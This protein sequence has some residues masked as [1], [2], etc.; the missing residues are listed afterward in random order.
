MEY[1]DVDYT[2]IK[3]SNVEYEV[4]NSEDVVIDTE[5][6]VLEEESEIKDE[7]MVDFQRIDWNNPVTVT[8]YGADLLKEIGKIESNKNALAADSETNR[9]KINSL[10]VKIENFIKNMAKDID[11]GEESISRS[12][13]SSC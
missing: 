4:I 1:E 12:I 13:L 6:E 11:Y 10:I 5:D 3:N 2:N 9:E 7:T 8:S